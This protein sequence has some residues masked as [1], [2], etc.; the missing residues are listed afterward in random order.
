MPFTGALGE[1]SSFYP[2]C[3]L[4]LT[5]PHPQRSRTRLNS[6]RDTR[7]QLKTPFSHLE[8]PTGRGQGKEM[9][10]G[11]KQVTS[12]SKP[13]KSA[14]RRVLERESDPPREGTGE[15]FVTEGSGRA[16]GKGARESLRGRGGIGSGLG[17]GSSAGSRGP[18]SPRRRAGPARLRSSSGAAGRSWPQPL[19]R[20]GP[21]SSPSPPGSGRRN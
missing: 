18:A 5:P 19:P 11:A 17:V 4:Q 8:R 20:L 2:T 6:V 13:S 21:Y 16:A 15:N 10:V 9:W 3:I 14:R 1:R 7:V 12:Q